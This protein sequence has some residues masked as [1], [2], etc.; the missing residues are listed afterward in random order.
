MSIPGILTPILAKITSL[1][2]WQRDFMVEAF[3]V[4][5]C[6][7]GRATFEN[8]SRY[9][10]YN[11]LT[12]RRHFRTFF[13]W[14]GF[15]T[16]LI[17]WSSGNF[18]GVLDCSFLAKSGQHTY[19]LDK[20][21]SGC[22][23]KAV[24]G[25]EISL[26]GCINIANKQTWVI[27]A[28]QT[29]AGLAA[30]DKKGYSRI[31]FYMEQVLDC[32]SALSP[33]VYFVA[34]GYYA[35]EK[36]FNTLRQQ[37]KHLI[38]KLRSDADL[39]MLWQQGRQPKQRGASRKYAGKADFQDLKSW[40]YIGEDSK[41]VYLQLYC[42]QLYSKRYHRTLVVVLVRNTKT[43][44]YVLLAS[45]DLQQEARQVVQYYQLRFQIEFVFRDAKQFTGLTHC[46]ARDQ[47]KLDFHINLS[48]AA[49]NVAHIALQEDPSYFN[50]FSADK[51]TC[52]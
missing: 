47:D 35:K 42:Q 12:F 23:G 38:T 11:E 37:G 17:D 43:N 19:G 15:N 32:L 34:D 8:L 22:L 9:S 13:D 45:T 27:D 36:V 14:V 46:Q 48:L 26:L 20:F 33:I 39:Y 29:P 50:S 2:K 30:T 49:I 21:W 18:I 7:Q 16:S 5:F 28:S 4:L 6:R 41:Y 31:D 40:Q 52:E 1:S 44:K 3:S 24:K 51:P 10:C 25:L